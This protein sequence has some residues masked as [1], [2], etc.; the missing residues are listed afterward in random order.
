MPGDPNGIQ[1]SSPAT[2]S[3]AAHARGPG[4]VKAKNIGNQSG[5]GDLPAKERE[6]AMQQISREFPSHYRDVIEQ[7][8]RKLASEEEQ[9]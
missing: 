9:K 4:E 8:F 2:R 1:S 5:W 6:E 7:Y 3:T